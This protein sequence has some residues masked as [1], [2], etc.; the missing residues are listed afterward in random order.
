MHDAFKSALKTFLFATAFKRNL[1]LLVHLLHCTVAAITFIRPFH[2]SYSTLAY[3]YLLFYFVLLKS[4][5]CFF[6]YCLVFLLSL[7]LMPIMFYVQHF[8]SDYGWKNHWISIFFYFIIQSGIVLFY[9]PISVLR[10]LFWLVLL[11]LINSEWHIHFTDVIFSISFS[12]SEQFT[13]L[14]FFFY[15]SWK[16][17]QV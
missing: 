16:N 17:M 13:Y 1:R 5:S 9:L 12:C 11:L 10:G 15:D 3:F 7:V 4:Y 14:F 2:L 6:L 8:V